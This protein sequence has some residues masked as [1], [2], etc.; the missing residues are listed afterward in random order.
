MAVHL[1]VQAD[2]KETTLCPNRE[3]SLR[4]DQVLDVLLQQGDLQIWLV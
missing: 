2:V 1:Q 3:R 4:R